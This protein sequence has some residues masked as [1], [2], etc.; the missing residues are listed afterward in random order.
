[1][2][3]P[4]YFTPNLGSIHV[5]LF[6]MLCHFMMI[7]T[8]KSIN[9]PNSPKNTLKSMK[10]IPFFSLPSMKIMVYIGR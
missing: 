5:F 4:K 10:I 3:S 8:S 2:A 1:M 9:K 7:S 6:N